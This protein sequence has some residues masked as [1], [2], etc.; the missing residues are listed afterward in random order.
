MF[1]FSRLWKVDARE[2]VLAI[3][4]KWVQLKHVVIGVVFFLMRF[5]VK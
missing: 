2:D 4:G 1:V 5:G 3:M